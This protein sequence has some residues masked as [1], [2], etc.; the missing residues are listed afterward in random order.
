MLPRLPG[1]RVRRWV[2]R[3]QVCLAGLGLEHWPS[4]VVAPVAA[5]E[6]D[7]TLTLR[8]RAGAFQVPSTAATNGWV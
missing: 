1:W 2:R 4:G 8:V 6:P 5:P 3:G 7:G